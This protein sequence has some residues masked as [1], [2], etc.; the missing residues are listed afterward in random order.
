[1]QKITRLILSLSL[2]LTQAQGAFARDTGCPLC[3]LAA[4]GDLDA[5]ALEIRLSHPDINGTNNSGSSAL[6]L[7]AKAGN[8]S[9]VDFLLE[10]GADLQLANGLDLQP[11][12]MAVWYGHVELLPKLMYS[13][14]VIN[15]Q[16]TDGM[17]ALHMAAMKGQAATLAWLIAH[18]ADLDVQEKH[19]FT[20]LHAAALSGQAAMLPLLLTGG[21]DFALRDAN[22]L[23]PIVLALQMGEP[24]SAGIIANHVLACL[25]SSAAAANNGCARSVGVHVGASS[26]LEGRWKF[27]KSSLDFP[28]ACREMILRFTPEGMYEG[29]DGAMRMTMLYRAVDETA[30]TVVHFT[31]LFDDGRPNCQGKTPAYVRKHAVSASLVEYGHDGDEIIVHFSASKKSPSMT[32]ARL[33]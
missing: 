4:D 23:S 14:E 24:P 15:R 25:A 32:F 27:K 30:A 12:H 16:D 10:H 33:R 13:K 29:S 5:M 28:A 18:G 6:H 17:T 19:G 1:M 26:R 22:G 11:F 21:A 2:F 8:E 7:A 9:V 3:K 20:A 31:Y